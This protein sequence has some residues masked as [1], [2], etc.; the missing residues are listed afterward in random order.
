ADGEICSNLRLTQAVYDE[1]E[2]RGLY[3]PPDPIAEEHASQAINA[4]LPDLLRQ[5]GVHYDLVIGDSLAALLG[6]V[7]TLTSS[8]EGIRRL[9][10]AA[11]Q[12]SSQ[13]AERVIFGGAEKQTRR[14]ARAKATK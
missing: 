4:V 7:R 2:Q 3:A 1:L 12:D 14:P 10:T 6:E 9:L 5:D 8:E 11:H 13:Y